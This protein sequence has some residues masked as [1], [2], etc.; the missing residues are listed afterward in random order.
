MTTIYK[1]VNGKCECKNCNND[2]VHWTYIHQF[3]HTNRD[4]YT[5]CAF[6]EGLPLY[7]VMLAKG[8]ITKDTKEATIQITDNEAMAMR[9]LQQIYDEEYENGTSGPTL[10]ALEN[11][12]IQWS[13]KYIT[14][15]GK[16]VRDYYKWNS[17]KGQYD[18]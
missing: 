2:A 16:V 17:K 14:D 5:W 1:F 11:I 9:V 6:R 7:D 15:L 8:M 18:P 13:K 10:A 12:I 4:E 3:P